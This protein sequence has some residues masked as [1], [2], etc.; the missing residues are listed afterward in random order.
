MLVEIG[1]DDFRIGV[2]FEFDD[3]ARVFVRL[4][5]DVADLGKHF[6]VHQLRDPLDQRGAV[7]AIRNLRDDDLFAAAFE[8]FYACFA[9]HFDAAPTSLEI[10]ADAIDAAD[11]ATSG[12]IRTL[13]VL[14]ELVQR[15][16]GIVDL[17]AD[18]VDDFAQIVRRNIRRH[19]NRDARCAVDEQVRKSCGEDR[20]LGARFVVIRHEI[21]RILIHIGHQRRAEMG[22]AR[23]GVAHRRRRITFDGSEI[24]LAVDEPFAHRPRLR[25]VDKRGVNHRFAV[26]MI[27]TAGVAADLCAF[28]VLPPR[29]KR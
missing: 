25:H 22:H 7:H 21:D 3:D 1:N 15:D 16:I 17:C 29:E 27:V 8:F 9:A 23:F 14:H 19:P 28:T 12:E 13:H 24:P 5:A 2:A 20:R 18:A 4:I 6:V 11:Y 10:L 26:R